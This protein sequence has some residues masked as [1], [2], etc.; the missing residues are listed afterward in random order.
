MKARTRDRIQ[1]VFGILA[2]QAVYYDFITIWQLLA[3][4]AIYIAGWLLW[5]LLTDVLFW[6]LIKSEIQRIRYMYPIRLKIMFVAFKNLIRAE[7]K[8]TWSLLKIKWVMLKWKCHKSGNEEQMEVMN[9][10]CGVLFD[11]RARIRHEYTITTKLM[12]L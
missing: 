12:C 9:K 1:I 11:M 2:A 4:F 6:M 5:N 3:G 10:I 7:A 8:V